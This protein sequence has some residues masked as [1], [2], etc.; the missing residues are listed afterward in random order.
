[1]LFLLLGTSAQAAMTGAQIKTAAS[2]K[3]YAYLGSK[4]GTISI[5]SNGTAWIKA[6][7]GWNS[8]GK[9][10][11]SGNKFC[12]QWKGKSASC[13]SWTSL[14]GGKIKTSNGYI[15]SPR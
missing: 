5:R 1:M 10:W 13:A 8:T 9:W 14:G 6:S 15:L 11:V 3:T 7:N 12:R 2:G 4:S